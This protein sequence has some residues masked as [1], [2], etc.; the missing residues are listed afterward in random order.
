MIISGNLIVGRYK[1]DF[2]PIVLQDSTEPYFTLQS[3]LSG[4]IPWLS[5]TQS[6]SRAIAQLLAFQLIP[7][8]IDVDKKSTSE[9]DNDWCLRSIYNFLKENQQ[10]KRLRAK[11]SKFFDEYEVDSV[12]TP[13]GVFSIPV[14]EGLESNPTHLIELI[15]EC[16]IETFEEA[17]PEEQPVWKQIVNATAFSNKA[18]SKASIETGECAGQ[19]NFQRKIIPVDALN[20]ALEEA[21]ERK[22]RNAAG[23][24]KQNLIVCAS[25]IDKAQNL[26]GLARTSEIFAADRLVIPNLEIAKMDNFRNLSA[27][28]GDLIQIEECKEKVS[29][30]NHNVF[31]CQLSCVIIVCKYQDLF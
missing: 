27:S 26:G 17:N 24:H 12:C 14:D 19:V 3:I 25:L 29:A 30:W 28:A 7:M 5:S 20:L 2:L 18:A 16:L 6:F 22:R 9:A 8:V 10:M 31:C 15:K 1:D 11:Q 23:R 21:K 13:E 4:T